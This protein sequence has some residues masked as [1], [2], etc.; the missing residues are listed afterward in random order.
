MG[1]KTLS[2]FFLAWV[3]VCALVI[4]PAFVAP[5]FNAGT[6][7]DLAFNGAVGELGGVQSGLGGN[8][9]ESMDHFRVLCLLYFGLPVVVF[10]STRLKDL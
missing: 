2:V 1:I 4:E 6:S 5:F 3:A 8:A 10:L 7:L 9:V